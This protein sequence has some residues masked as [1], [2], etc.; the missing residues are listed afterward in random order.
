M[1]RPQVGDAAVVFGRPMVVSSVGSDLVRCVD[2]AESERRE[3]ARKESAALRAK[4]IDGVGSPVVIRARL[5]V[6][7]P[8]AH[9]AVPALDVRADLLTYDPT[10][11]WRRG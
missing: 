2:R 9:A 5:D 3:E 1:K 7:F 8:V 4:L 11:V 10:G 6:L